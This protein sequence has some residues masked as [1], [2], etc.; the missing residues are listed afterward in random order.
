MQ[1]KSLPHTQNIVLIGFMGSGKSSIG[2][3]ICAL[4]DYFF[5][6]TDNL[7]ESVLGK[8]I[9]E[10]FN[11]LGE[12]TFRTMESRL[13]QWLKINAKHCVIATGGG[14]P[15]FN[16]MRN[17]GVVV[18]LDESFEN[19]TKRLSQ[20]ERQSR[21]LFNDIA[22]AKELF[23]TRSSVY[24]KQAD[25]IINPKDCALS[26]KQIAQKIMD[27]ILHLQSNKE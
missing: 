26:P 23:Q 15:I 8:S 18:F 11:E 10:I 19:I 3:E 27:C 4:D 12:S 16:D 5:C 9:S 25:I 24:K 22:K 7:V 1:K 14:M 17:L 20:N 13:L 2:K 6:D 21:P